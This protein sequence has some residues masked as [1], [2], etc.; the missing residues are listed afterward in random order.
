MSIPFNATATKSGLVQ[1]YEKECGFEYG[2]VSGSAD[3][4][5]EFVADANEALDDF[6]AFVLA[7]SGKVRLDDIN[8]ASDPIVYVNI[9]SGTRKYSIFEDAA[10]N[11]MLEV[12]RIF[13]LPS[14][15][16]TIY[17]PL[18]FFDPKISEDYTEIYELDQSGEP[19]RFALQGA[20]VLFDLIPNYS[21]ANGVKAVISREASYFASSDTTKKPG[22]PGSFHKWFY[23][24]PAKNYARIHDLSNHQKIVDEIEILKKDILRGMAN[25]LPA[26][27]KIMRNQ[28]VSCE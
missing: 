5:A 19:S 21:I 27:Q 26:E 7:Q 17:K 12:L 1:K 10:L 23:L 15:T 4:L 2:D 20:S 25:R 6:W 16:A 9:V 14:A 18:T 3:R 28:E 13:V 8:H 24:V 22:V 11:D